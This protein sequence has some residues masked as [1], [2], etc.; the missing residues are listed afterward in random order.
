MFEVV[1]HFKINSLFLYNSLK[2]CICHRQLVYQTSVKCF[3]LLQ[4]YARN[5]SFSSDHPHPV[6]ISGRPPSLG[7]LLVL[8]R[9]LCGHLCATHAHLSELREKLGSV[10]A[11]ATA[12]I[13]AVI[14]QEEVGIEAN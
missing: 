10:E 4:L 14:R 5:K 7:H 11:M 2:S 1:I 9:N 13:T 12:E 6:S 3:N 8:L